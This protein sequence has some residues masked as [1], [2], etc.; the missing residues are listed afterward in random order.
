MH[1]WLIVHITSGIQWQISNNFEVKNFILNDECT[2][3]LKLQAVINTKEH[4][5]YQDSDVTTL[6]N[7]LR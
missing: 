7:T 3:L 4:S 5:L 2:C 6:R 1:E